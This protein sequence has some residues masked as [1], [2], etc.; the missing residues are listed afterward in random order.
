[1]LSGYKT[2]LDHIMESCWGATVCHCWQIKSCDKIFDG[3]LQVLCACHTAW[4]WGGEQHRALPQTSILTG[5]H[6]CQA[7]WRDRNSNEPLSAPAIRRPESLWKMS[8]GY[9]WRTKC[10][11]SPQGKPWIARVGITWK[12]GLADALGTCHWRSVFCS[13]RHR[14]PS[15]GKRTKGTHVFVNPF[16][17]N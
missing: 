15:E 8:Y 11:V 5:R 10:S 12:G 7:Y 3:K 6:D 14:S 16:V 1:M 4:G 2:H 17:K 13:R 9:F